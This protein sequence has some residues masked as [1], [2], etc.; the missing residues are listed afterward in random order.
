MLNLTP[1]YQMANPYS[2][3][4]NPISYLMA[5][6]GPVRQQFDIVLLISDLE[7][8]EGYVIT[9]LQ[10]TSICGVPD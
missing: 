6:H 5:K 3:K 2:N 1:F 9:I 7:I 4:S 10:N 8:E